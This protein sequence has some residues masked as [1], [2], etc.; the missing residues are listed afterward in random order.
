MSIDSLLDD[1]RC[2]AARYNVRMDDLLL[3]KRWS[4]GQHKEA[5]GQQRGLDRWGNREK[6]FFS[7]GG[8][9]FDIDYESLLLGPSDPP[10]CEELD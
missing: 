6:V 2:I 5:V 3:C 10:D 8:Q 9:P 1:F 4:E 7:D